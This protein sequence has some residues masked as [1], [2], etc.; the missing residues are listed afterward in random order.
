MFAQ[1]AVVDRASVSSKD[2]G[3]SSSPPAALARRA[4]LHEQRFRRYFLATDAK[5][6]AV[7]MI[8]VSLAFH[9]TARN[10]LL[11]LAG[12]STLY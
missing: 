8:V 4:L 6:S 2:A 3:V 7:V 1:G 11:L 12:S 5:Q 10:D 9:A